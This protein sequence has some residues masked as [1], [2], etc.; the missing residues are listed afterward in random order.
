M[1]STLPAVPGMANASPALKRSLRAV[2]CVEP[3]LTD[4]LCAVIS[5]F[6][7]GTFD[8]EHG[9]REWHPVTSPAV[10][11]FRWYEGTARYA[12]VPKGFVPRYPHWWKLWPYTGSRIWSL[13]IM[14]GERQVAHALAFLD[15]MQAL[16]FREP[17]QLALVALGAMPSLGQQWILGKAAQEAPC[18]PREWDLDGD[19]QVSIGDIKG[20]L[21]AISEQAKA[22]PRVIVSE[23][24][25]QGSTLREASL[26]L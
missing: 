26:S 19:G 24:P 1:I 18:L 14:P 7:N 6:T 9:V 8:P 5:F 15:A 21:S 4:P 12:G 25:V 10:G 13:A 16:A 3:G 2:D 22:L 20:R 17:Y 23:L 11:L